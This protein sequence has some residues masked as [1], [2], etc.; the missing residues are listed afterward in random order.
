AGIDTVRNLGNFILQAGTPD[1]F[2]TLGTRVI[3]G[4]AFDERD[5][6]NSQRVVVVGEGM[7]RVLWPN[8]EA[9]GQCLRIA[10][11]DAPCTRVIGIAEDVRI[12]TLTDEREYAYYI[13][14]SQYGEEM[15]AQL[16][17]R[18][19]GAAASHVETLRRRLQAEMPGAAY[20]NVRPL[21]EMVDP[22]LRAWSFGATMFVAFGALALV[23]AAIGLYSMIAYGVAQRTRELGV[24]MA[25]GASAGHVIRMIVATAL[26]LVVVGLAIG[27]AIAMWAAPR[28]E[29]LMF[30]ASTRDPAVYGAVAAMLVGVALVA[31]VVPAMRALRVDPNTVLRAD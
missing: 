12:R 20:V 14:A 2:R 8:Q 30:E 10:A 21:R 22:S 7:A 3:R 23:L 17:V 6:E 1:Y 18:L 29:P 28:L 5:R 27:G 26:Q 11:A 15:Y 4:R 19:D 25:L 16:F 13:P 24:R 31:S 9:I